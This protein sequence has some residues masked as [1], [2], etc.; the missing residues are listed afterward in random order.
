[1]PGVLARQMRL[2]MTSAHTPRAARRLRRR[3]GPPCLSLPLPA[4]IRRR[5]PGRLVG[6]CHQRGRPPPG[7]GIDRS[8]GHC[9]AGAIRE[10]SSVTPAIARLQGITLAGLYQ[11]IIS[12]AGQ[13]TRD[14]QSQGAIVDELY[15]AI[16]NVLDEIDRW[17]SA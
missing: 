6:V 10:T 12:E 14:G 17:L 2:Q 11:I 4:S 9:P 5:R 1:V 16:E 3:S 15:P 8:P 13:R 7:P